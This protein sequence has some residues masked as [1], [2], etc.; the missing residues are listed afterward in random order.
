M[1]RKAELTTDTFHVVILHSTVVRCLACC[2]FTCSLLF[3]LTKASV[4]RFLFRRSRT[5][6]LNSLI[7]MVIVVLKVTTTVIVIL[8]E[9]LTVMATVMVGV[10]TRVMVTVKV[11]GIY[12]NGNGRSDCGDECDGDVQYPP[13]RWVKLY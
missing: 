12:G 11:M 6:C 5:C 9:T 7:V 4:L 10:A 8:K 13:V 2:N 3:S 1:G